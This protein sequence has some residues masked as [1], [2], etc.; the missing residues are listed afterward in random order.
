MSCVATHGVARRVLAQ[1]RAGR[2][3][4]EL[5]EEVAAPPDATLERA[6]SPRALLRLPG[7]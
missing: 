1:R 3:P 4:L 6:E 2:A 5:R 7:A